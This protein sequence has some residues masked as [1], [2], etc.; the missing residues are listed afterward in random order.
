MGFTALA[1]GA[2]SGDEFERC[3]C[4]FTNFNTFL[5]FDTITRTQTDFL[6]P[7]FSVGV[8]LLYE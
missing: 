5:S 6:F 8:L 1:E 3:R 2:V 4:V 7:L